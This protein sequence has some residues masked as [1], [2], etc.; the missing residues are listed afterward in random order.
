MHL[1][2]VALRLEGNLVYRRL[3]AGCHC[4]LMLLVW[5]QEWLITCKKWWQHSPGNSSCLRTNF[6]FILYEGKIIVH[7]LSH[8]Q[9]EIT[10]VDLYLSGE[11]FELVKETM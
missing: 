10:T 6:I 11:H 2:V 3:W 9:V 4:A 5:H 8:G 7:A 1:Q